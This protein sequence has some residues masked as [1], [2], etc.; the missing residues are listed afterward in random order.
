MLWI[1]ALPALA[2][3]VMLA[4][5]LGYRGGRKA[6]ERVARLREEPM[7]ERRYCGT[8]LLHME[9]LRVADEIRQLE[10][11]YDDA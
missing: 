6:A 5:I 3:I 1:L 11:M 8:A 7:R 9:Q 4:Y 2:V 10:R